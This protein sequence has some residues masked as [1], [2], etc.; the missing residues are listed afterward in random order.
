MLISDRDSARRFFI[1]TWKKYRQG[2]ALEPLEDLVL[3]VILDHLE[4]QSLLED[5]DQA[6][7]WDF[8]PEAGRTNPFLHMCMHVAIREQVGADHPA[9][10]AALYQNLLRQHGNA[11]ELEHRIMECLGEALWIAQRNHTLPDERAYL[12][13]VRNLS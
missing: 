10:I 11:H 3:G 2:R 5:P 6:L 4:Y 7:A 13:C 12:D 8:P 9:G 1:D